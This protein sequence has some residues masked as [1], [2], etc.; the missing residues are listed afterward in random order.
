MDYKS[1]YQTPI[2]LVVL[3]MG[4]ALVK[5]IVYGLYFTFDLIG[6]V[7]G[8][9]NEVVG[10]HFQKMQHS[11]ILHQHSYNFAGSFLKKCFYFRVVVQL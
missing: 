9:E 6:T 5:M 2:I 4:A 3:G 1:Y 8:M 11:N 10:L 7:I